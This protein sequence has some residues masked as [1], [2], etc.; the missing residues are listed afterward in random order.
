[1]WN[2][3]DKRMCN[4]AVEDWTVFSLVFLHFT[5][6]VQ[7]KSNVDPSR[8]EGGLEGADRAT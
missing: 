5:A 1:M 4:V 7:S 3:A 8:A 2:L 6:V